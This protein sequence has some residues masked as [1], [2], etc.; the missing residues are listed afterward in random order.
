MANDT[1]IRTLDL[2]GTKQRVETGPIQFNNDWPGIFIR[3]D[4]ALGYLIWLERARDQQRDDSLTK[5]MLNDLITLLK[6]CNVR[7]A[8]TPQD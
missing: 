6:S 4:D 8:E 5:N 3:G 2:I 7:H 1:R